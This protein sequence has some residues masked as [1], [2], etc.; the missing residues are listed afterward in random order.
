VTLSK[1]ATS[2]LRRGFAIAV[3]ACSWRMFYAYAYQLLRGTRVF[4]RRYPRFTHGHDHPMR[5]SLAATG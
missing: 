5:W 2:P 1:Y 4:D 3:L